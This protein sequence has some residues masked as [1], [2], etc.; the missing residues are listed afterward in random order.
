[1]QHAHSD[2]VQRKRCERCLRS[3]RACICHCVLTVESAI[4]VVILQHP[5][6]TTHIKGSAR[7]LHLCLPNSVL[8]IGENFEEDLLRQHLFQTNQ[9]TRLLYPTSETDVQVA[10]AIPQARPCERQTLVLLDATWRKSR[11]MLQN[12]PL[13]LSLPRVALRETPASRYTIRTAH[14]PD[15]LSSLEACAYALMQVAKNAHQFQP[16]LTAFKKFNDLQIAFGVNKLR[17]SNSH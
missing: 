5:D 13:L 1:M 15:Q 9:Q 11:Q 4:E 16:L 10:T 8:L 3:H 7:L 14:Q 2:T 6:E 12:N 17:R